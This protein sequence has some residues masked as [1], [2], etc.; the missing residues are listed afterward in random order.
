M[1]KY[2]VIAPTILVFV[3]TLLVFF[4]YKSS[5][6]ALYKD[7]ILTQDEEIQNAFKE[8]E[9]VNCN[10][11][12]NNPEHAFVSFQH[13]IY[14]EDNTEMKF[15]RV[16]F[17]LL[18]RSNIFS[19]KWDIQRTGGTTITNTTFPELVKMVKEDCSQFQADY[20]NPDPDGIDWGYRE[21]EPA[22]TPEQVKEE[23]DQR[24]YSMVKSTRYQ[25]TMFTELQKSK[26]I[27]VYG[28]IM[29]MTDDEVYQVAKRIKDNGFD[30]SLKKYF[31]D[32]EGKP[33]LKESK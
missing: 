19:Q 3:L 5:Y 31:Y 7:K 15:W 2:F 25:L 32:S 17:Y 23:E 12:L 14:P 10:F 30:E 13:Y 18:K 24:Y 1:K 26:F 11:S 20:N 28:N 29:T 22:P 6:S 21:A 27:E 9:M 33:I 4:S 16:D 8:Y